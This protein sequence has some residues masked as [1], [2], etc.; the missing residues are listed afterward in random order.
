MGSETGFAC[1]L[2][3]AVRIPC[4]DRDGVRGVVDDL[5]RRDDAVVASVVRRDR[6]FPGESA[7][8]RACG[9]LQVAGLHQ[10]HRFLHRAVHVAHCRCLFS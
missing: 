6:R 4:V 7:R 3:A 10:L 9:G 8:D 2:G 5:V 1:G